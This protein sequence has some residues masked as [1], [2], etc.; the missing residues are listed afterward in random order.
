MTNDKELIDKLKLNLFELIHILDDYRRRE[1]MEM[2][3]ARIH[4]VLY[5]THIEFIMYNRWQLQE[6]I[7]F[8]SHEPFKSLN[9]IE[10]HEYMPYFNS[11]TNVSLVEK[12]DMLVNHFPDKL[13]FL[14]RLHGEEKYYG[15][16]YISFDAERSPS[17]YGLEKVRMEIENFLKILY[18]NR[19]DRYIHRRDN[20]LFQLS[21]K[22]HSIHRTTDILSRVVTVLR[23]LFSGFNITLLMSKE[24]EDS[25]LPIKLIE[26]TSDTPLSAGTAAFINNT[27][28][29][30]YDD[31][32]RS[33]TFYTPLSGA[34]G[35]YGVLQVEAPLILVLEQEEFKFVEKFSNMVGRAIERTTLYQSS[36]QQV[37]DLQTINYTTHQLN[38]NLDQE[39]IISIVKKQIFNSCYAE[40]FAAVLCY[41]EKEELEILQGSSD[42]FDTLTGQVFIEYIHNEVMKTGKA[43]FLGDFQG[44]SLDVPFKSIMAIPL[45]S[46]DTILGVI[47]VVH[48]KP[49]FFSFDAFKLIQSIVQHASLALSNTI[50]KEQLKKTVIT[51]YL[52]Q[53]YS[54]NYLDSII[55][56][57]MNEGQLGSFILF[58]IDN[59]KQ[60]NDTYG[61]YIGDQILITVAKLIRGVIH[62]EDIAARWG[63]EEFAIYLPNIDVEGAVEIANGIRE[64]VSEHTEPKVSVSCGV[65]MWEVGTE[66]TIENLFIRTDEALYKAKGSGKNKVVMK[67]IKETK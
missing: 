54:R 1:I 62:K 42:Y 46:S 19:H 4:K 61:H 50:L 18:K 5:T 7:I 51:D 57:H 6:K 24:Y 48:S 25:N 34:Q 56:S 16:L 28:Q 47:I 12:D 22:L 10:L 23:I 64:K 20:I 8:Y 9:E 52:T 2:L 30:E 58:D 33:T 49:Y 21:T 59:F 29:V 45:Q 38:L 35:V 17:K 3:S 27:I 43:V 39:E 11:R 36:T 15:L 44:N 13:S 41:E 31:D 14:L 53:L 32:K 66:D 37:A 40:Y 26:Y 65:S 63:G 60:V 55:K 67:M